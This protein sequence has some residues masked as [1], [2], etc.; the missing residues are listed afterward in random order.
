MVT[1]SPQGEMG[2]RDKKYLLFLSSV[3]QFRGGIPEYKL[4]AHFICEGHDCVEIV[5]FIFEILASLLFRCM[6]PTYFKGKYGDFYANVP[7]ISD[8]AAYVAWI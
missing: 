7:F 8:A 2:I 5:L 1:Y 6:R 3:L 4:N